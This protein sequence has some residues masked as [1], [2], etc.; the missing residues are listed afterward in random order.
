MQPQTRQ[1]LRT[2]TRRNAGAIRLTADPRGRR[3]LTLPLGAPEDAAAQFLAGWREGTA[4]QEPPAS[5]TEDEARTLAQLWAGRLGIGTPS[6]GFFR[7]PWRWGLCRWQEGAVLLNEALL[8]L[9]PQ[10][11]EEALLH[12]LE[13]FRV[14]DHSPQFWWEMTAWLPDWPRREGQLRGWASAHRGRK[15]PG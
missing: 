1:P 2:V 6:I 5:S 9:P 13:H 11:L 7:D 10:V 8:R 15:T 3:T 14:H 4:W 12:E